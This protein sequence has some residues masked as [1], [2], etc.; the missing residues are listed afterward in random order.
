MILI[1]FNKEK[2]I[3]GNLFANNIIEFIELHSL[4]NL[5]TSYVPEVRRIN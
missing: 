5:Q 4:V 2:Y 3:R 1:D